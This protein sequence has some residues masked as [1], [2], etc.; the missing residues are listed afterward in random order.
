M[1]LTQ[2]EDR[3]DNEFPGIGLSW[4]SCGTGWYPILKKLVQRVLEIDSNIQVLQVK[5]KFGDIRFYV[6]PTSDAVNQVIGDFSLLS[7]TVCES[8]GTQDGVTKEGGWIKTFCPQCR[9]DN[10]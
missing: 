4:I 7:S 3:L 1:K 9:I 5:E 8:C 6:T 2:I 10:K